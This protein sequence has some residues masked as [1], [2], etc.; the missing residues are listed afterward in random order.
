MVKLFQG[1]FQSVQSDV[2]NWVEVYKPRIFD[3]KQ[4]MIVLEHNLIILLTFL[5]D[6]ES[7]THKV[8][9]KLDRLKK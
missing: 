9:Y 1:D 2:N 7:E 3:F 4:S 8:E 5:Y 6:A